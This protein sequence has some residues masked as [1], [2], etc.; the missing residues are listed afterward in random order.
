LR[1]TNRQNIL[2]TII[3][4]LS[5]LGFYYPKKGNKI[6]E[7]L[8]QKLAIYPPDADINTSNLSGGNQQKIL[9]AKWLSTKPKVLI[10]DEPTRGVDVGAKKMIHET[11]VNLAE[12]G[13]AVL[14]LSSDL[15]ELVALSDRMIVI[16]QG[17][18]I[19]ELNKDKD[20]DESTVLLAANGERS[21]F[22]VEY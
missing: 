18:S 2:S 8:Y 6:V 3:P 7:D 14:L 17:H 10:L 22:S 9:L 4:R 16:K 11:I 21:V 1:L 15:P 20:L 12:E 5:N 13:V 19:A